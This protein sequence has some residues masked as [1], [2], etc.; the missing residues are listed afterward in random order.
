MSDITI[1]S[2]IPVDQA[3]GSY[4][5]RRALWDQVKNLKVEELLFNK[6][7]R[8]LLSDYFDR[9]EFE[10][11]LDGFLDQATNEGRF[12]INYDE[13]K[14]IITA[15]LN[16]LFNRLDE[17]ASLW[18]DDDKDPVTLA[19]LP[20]DWKVIVL[21]R[22]NGVKTL[23][24]LGGKTD[25]ELRQIGVTPAPLRRIRAFCLKHCPKQEPKNSLE[26]ASKLAQA[27]AKR[28]ADAKLQPA[29]L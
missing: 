25:K 29:L 15:R 16:R 17:R 5:C 18:L 8:F 14:R 4:E 7:E 10:P 1:D 24:E 3:R 13:R 6:E 23:L 20:V 22:R 28:V 11:K 26:P 2:S 27:R 21:L 19:F 9:F 12:P